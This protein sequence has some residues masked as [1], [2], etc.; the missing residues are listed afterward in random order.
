MRTQVRMAGV[1]GVIAGVA[2]G[3]WIDQNGPPSPVVGISR[4]LRRM[5]RRMSRMAGTTHSRGYHFTRKQ[6]LV[7]LLVVMLV[8][9]WRRYNPVRSVVLTGLLLLVV[10]LI[11][12]R[13]GRT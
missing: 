8:V 10:V 2:T 12:S 1:S 11:L 5:T 4:T 13:F 3:S 9:L 7:M 6:R